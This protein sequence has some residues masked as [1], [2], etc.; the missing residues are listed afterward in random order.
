MPEIVPFYFPMS[1]GRNEELSVLVRDGEPLFRAEHACVLLGLSNVAQAISRLDGE[2]KVS[3]DI[4][5]SDL[6]GQPANFKWF[7]TESGLYNL[8]FA[9]RTGAAKTFK[10][11]VTKEVLPSIRKTGSYGKPSF[12]IPQ[13]F[14]EA[15]ELAAAEM[16]KSEAL[17]IVVVE[18]ERLLERSNTL[19]DQPHFETRLSAGCPWSKE[20]IVERQGV[21]KKGYANKILLAVG[22]IIPSGLRAN[23]YVANPVYLVD[24][25]ISQTPKANRHLAAW[26]AELRFGLKAFELVEK[27]MADGA[28]DEFLLKSAKSHSADMSIFRKAG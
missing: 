16:R 28:L 2:D 13:T 26:D 21:L 9:S 3:I 23:S 12:Q 14:A 18:K 6:P 20:Y 22:L 10:A 1:D 27:A 4:T 19:P 15:L 17:A 5:S 24:G 7:V 8:I 11:W 25:F